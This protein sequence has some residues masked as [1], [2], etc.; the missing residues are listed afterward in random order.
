MKKI[1]DNSC[2]KISKLITNEYST[3]FSLGIRLFHKEI[4]MPIYAIYG[5]VRLADEIVDTFDRYDQKI[6]FQRFRKDY[7]L[8][9]AEGISL[10]PVL[11][12]FQFV[13]RKYEIQPFVESFMDSMALDLEK[14]QYLSKEEYEQYIYG[15]ADVVGLMCLKVF[16]NG[17]KKR[18]E[19][20]KPY[21]LKLGSAFQKVNFL[22]DIKHDTDELGRSYFPNIDFDNLDERKKQEIIVEIKNDFMEALIGI[23]KLPSNS[24]LGVYVAYKYYA[25]LLFKLNKKKPEQIL[26]ERIRVSDFKKVFILNKAVVRY[27]FNVL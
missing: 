14:T 16:I 17:D 22:R 25:N 23:K 11:N 26:S 19:E 5:F 4:R 9:L 1:F 27:M 13:V 2:Y 24:R 15:S 21:A 7:E 18:F 12:A 6:L 3:S 8:A 10:N 20:L